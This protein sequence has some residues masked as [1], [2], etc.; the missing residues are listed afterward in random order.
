MINYIDLTKTQRFPNDC[1]WGVRTFIV[2]STI[3][4]R[5]QFVLDI[6]AQQMHLDLPVKGGG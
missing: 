6:D 5:Q 2:L 1:A 4:S 3:V